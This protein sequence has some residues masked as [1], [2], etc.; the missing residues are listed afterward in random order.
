MLLTVMGRSGTACS[1][2]HAVVMTNGYA[3]N[4]LGLCA[5]CSADKGATAG[6]MPRGPQLCNGANALTSDTTKHTVYY[7]LPVRLA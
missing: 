7:W 1:P 6:P 5:S 3:T 2:M 4:L